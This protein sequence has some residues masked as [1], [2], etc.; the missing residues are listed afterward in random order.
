MQTPRGLRETGSETPRGL[1]ETGSEIPRGL[2]KAGSKSREQS[3][4]RFD[5]I[6]EVARAGI[7]F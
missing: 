7:S 1:R 2:R 4:Y 5:G 6:G 3:G